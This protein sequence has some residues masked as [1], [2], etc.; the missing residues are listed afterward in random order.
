[1]TVDQAN[2]LLFPVEIARIISI[3]IHGT[4]HAKNKEKALNQV[5]ENPLKQSL[6][7]CFAY[8]NIDITGDPNAHG[9][10]FAHPIQS[11]RYTFNSTGA[12]S[13]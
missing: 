13:S 2:M 4:K 1:M 7:H 8:I 6:K 10:V 3:L 12:N 9:C 11:P 5:S